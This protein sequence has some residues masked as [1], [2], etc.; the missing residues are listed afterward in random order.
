[1]QP[2][3]TVSALDPDAVAAFLTTRLGNAVDPHI[4][5]RVGH[6][7]WSKAFYVRCADDRELVVRFSA[8]DE[9]FLKDRWALRFASPRLPI[10]RLLEIGPGFFSPTTTGRQP[11]AILVQAGLR[12][13]HELV[14]G[15]DG[16]ATVLAGFEH[17]S[18]S[19]GGGAVSQ[20]GWG[21]RIGLALGV[22]L[23]LGP[24]RVLA[25]MQLDSSP[26]QLPGMKGQGGT[27]MLAG[28]LL[29]VR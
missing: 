15:L 21:G 3:N 6:G 5:Q 18:L 25:Q 16:H 26:S 11:L 12:F 17:Q 1:M 19:A 27:Q 4:V 2:N 10:P 7:E 24:G 8:R 29:T 23:R 20:D 22:N 13:H 9:D 28:Y 14:H